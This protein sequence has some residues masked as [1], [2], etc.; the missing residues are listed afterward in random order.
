MAHKIKFQGK[1][2]T[3]IEVEDV[4]DPSIIRYRA[5]VKNSKGEEF[6]YIYSCTGHHLYNS[7][8]QRI[9]ETTSV[10]EWDV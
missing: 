9:A 10:Q 2:Y 1:T 3:V 8:N 4:G 6:T 7:K 5:K